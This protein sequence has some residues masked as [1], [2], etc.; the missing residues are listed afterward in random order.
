M[1]DIT[2]MTE[3]F[4]SSLQIQY[5]CVVTMEIVQNQVSDV[6]R[7]INSSFIS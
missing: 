3:L 7:L 4:P 5:I 2:E 6:S 1:R